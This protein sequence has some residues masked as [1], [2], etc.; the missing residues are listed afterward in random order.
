MKIN[1]GTIVLTWLW[2]SVQVLLVLTLM[3]SAIYEGDNMKNKDIS[4][5][6]VEVVSSN[7]SSFLE[8]SRRWT[9]FINGLKSE[10]SIPRE[11]LDVT[12]VESA[13]EDAPVTP[14][15]DAEIVPM[16]LVPANNQMAVKYSRGNTI[17]NEMVPYVGYEKAERM[18]NDLLLKGLLDASMR[19]TEVD[20]PEKHAVRFILN[21]QSTAIK[22]PIEPESATGIL[23]HN[24]YFDALY[25]TEARG[26]EEYKVIFCVQA[27]KFILEQL[28]HQVI[29]REILVRSLAENIAIS[30]LSNTDITEVIK[31]LLHFG[32]L[33]EHN[34][35]RED[36]KKAKWRNKRFSGAISEHE[37][38][39]LYL[40]REYAVLDDKGKIKYI[41]TADNSTYTK[42]NLR[43]KFENMQ[44]E[45][46]NEKTGRV[47]MVNPVDI[48]VESRYRKEYKGVA[49]DPSN[50]LDPSIYN[51]FRG[52]PFEA[53]EGSARIKKFKDFVKAVI[54]S[55]DEQTF[56]I[57]WSF[58]AQIFQKP[59]EKKGTA[60]ILLSKEGAGK[61]TLMKVMGKLM[62]DYYMSSTDHKRIITPFNKH[63]EKVILFY[64]N[65]AKFTDNRLT[66]NKLKNIITE[67]DATSEIKGGDTYAT[68]NYT[69][70]VID[71]NEGIP[72]E[73]TSDSRRFINVFVSHIRIGDQEFWAELNAEIETDGF[74]EALL[75][76]LMH[77]DYSEWEQFLR[78]PPKVEVTLEQIQENFSAVDA[79]WQHCL[80]EGRIPYVSYDLTP[81]DRLNI[82]NLDMFQSFHKWC[83]VNRYKHGLNSSTFGKAFRED[84]LGTDSGLDTKGKITIAGER[85]HSHIY[86]SIDKCRDTFMKRKHINSLDFNGDEWKLP[87]IS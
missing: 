65:E 46:F 78:V 47:G 24:N 54:C 80:E 8:C 51:L 75:Y 12:V 32:Y 74:Y 62:G 79:W 1:Q 50:N 7:K 57:V 38:E 10:P 85:K 16:A 26:G 87:Y 36:V 14:L 33:P 66:I 3:R 11:V 58:F 43:L 86:E 67:V 40:L 44:I 77:F 34:S 84:A 27:I 19:V 13:E 21:N 82:R 39:A 61:G 37:M 70:I 83:S 55:D 68:H 42:P 25:K 31:V 18:T 76:D 73:Q 22:D 81:D 35:F 69:H 49:F 6:E 23:S 59:Y 52:Y 2:I 28:S 17:M 15:I 45:V 72:V 20:G 29:N 53:Q 4:D 48:Y 5:S 9:K 60:L 30:G 63:L 71:G 56:M 41:N 64:A